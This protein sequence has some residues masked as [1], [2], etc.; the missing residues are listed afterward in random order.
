MAGWSSS[1]EDLE[2]VGSFGEVGGSLVL[3]RGA[4]AT[5]VRQD[6]ASLIDLGVVSRG[7]ACM[8]LACEVGHDAP[9]APHLPLSIEVRVALAGV[10]YQPL[11]RAP[12]L[13]RLR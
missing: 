5:M 11:E 7:L 9:W 6:A 4:A 1:P 12:A 13:W 8:L 2:A 3:P 10:A